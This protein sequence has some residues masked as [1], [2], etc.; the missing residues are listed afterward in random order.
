VKYAGEHF[1]PLTQTTRH[2]YSERS[3]VGVRHPAW[4][5][6]GVK[7]DPKRSFTLDERRFRFLRQ[8]PIGKK[9]TPKFN[10]LRQEALPIH[11]ED[12]C[13]SGGACA[14]DGV[15]LC[16]YLQYRGG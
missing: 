8:C 1:R 3:M 12:V 10:D 11:R 2:F 7:V 13:V 16:P 15:S 14:P 4:A 5:K 9:R 6:D